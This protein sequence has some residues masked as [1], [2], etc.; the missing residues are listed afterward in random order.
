MHSSFPQS[1][2]DRQE[3]MVQVDNRRALWLEFMEARQR[4]WGFQEISV[5]GFG[6]AGGSICGAGPPCQ[7]MHPELYPQITAS[8]YSC[9]VVLSFRSFRID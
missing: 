4:N 2:E 7:G 1:L 6:Q 9:N 5:P 8:V 3:W